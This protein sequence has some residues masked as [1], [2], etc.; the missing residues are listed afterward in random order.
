MSESLVVATD[1]SESVDALND[2]IIRTLA[3]F[4]EPATLVTLRKKL[5][6]PYQCEEEILRQTLEELTRR[7][8]VHRFSPYRGKADRYWGRSPKEYA[9]WL[10]TTQTV[11]R[12]ATKNELVKQFKARLKEL[13]NKEIGDLVQQLARSGKLHSGRFLGSRS[14]RY[15]ATPVDAQALLDNAIDQIARRFSTSPADVR[16]LLV[17]DDQPQL[18]ETSASPESASHESLI[19]DAISEMRPGGGGGTIVPIAELRRYLNFKIDRDMFD[20]TLRTL[21]RS[22]R[23]DFT[24]HPDPMSLGDDDRQDRLLGE[25][26]TVYDM[27]VVRR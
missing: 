10:L 21:E 16:S 1:A 14:M 3:T 6:V 19:M 27:L 9:E 26:G 25:G 7:N 13:S 17:E 8:L 24:V 11:G 4:D 22:G 20:E 15:S 12:F 23:I 18:E 5:P 2:V